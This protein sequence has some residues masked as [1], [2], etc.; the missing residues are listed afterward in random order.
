MSNEPTLEKIED[1]N[2]LSGSKKKVVWAVIIGGLVVGVILASIKV[3][4][5]KVDDSII[6]KD[7]ISKVPVR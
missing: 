4:Y 1:Y 6:I 5:N 3:I 7:P 2:T